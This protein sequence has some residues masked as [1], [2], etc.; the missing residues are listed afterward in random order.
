MSSQAKRSQRS[1][2]QKK[3]VG[4]SGQ[5]QTVGVTHR[6]VRCAPDYPGPVRLKCPASVLAGSRRLKITRQSGTLTNRGR[7]GA[8]K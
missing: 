4:W 7:L 5:R 3:K 2:A 8:S 1:L 6:T